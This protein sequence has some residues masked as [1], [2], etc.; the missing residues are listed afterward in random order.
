MLIIHKAGGGQGLIIECWELTMD[1]AE[2]RPRG[3]VRLLLY[4]QD[5]KTHHPRCASVISFARGITGAGYCIGRERM[6]VTLV[7]MRDGTR[8]LVRSGVRLISLVGSSSTGGISSQ[9][10]DGSS[11]AFMKEG[12]HVSQNS[13]GARGRAWALR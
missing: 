6:L 1:I 4:M 9:L 10:F 13:K 2:G 12:T 8:R 11:R 3:S 5:L 7:Q